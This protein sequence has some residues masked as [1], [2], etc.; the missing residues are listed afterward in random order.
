M[1]NS[2]FAF[3]F[4][5]KNNF[6]FSHIRSRDMMLVVKLFDTECL[7][8][9]LPPGF[10]ARTSRKVAGSGKGYDR[11]LVY[12]GQLTTADEQQLTVRN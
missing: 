2:I 3:F 7:S 12:M 8:S 10:G 5:A 6:D 4:V 1:Q 9:M 11:N